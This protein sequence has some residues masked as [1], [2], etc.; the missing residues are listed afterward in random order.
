MWSQVD[1]LKHRAWIHADQAK[2]KEAIPVP[3]NEDATNVVTKQ[4]GKHSVY[5]FTYRGH[6]IKQTNTKAWRNDPV[7]FSLRV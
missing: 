5:V 1:L 4:I 6:S 3:L 2:G 7:N